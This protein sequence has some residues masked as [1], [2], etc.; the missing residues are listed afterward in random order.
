MPKI[1]G[2]DT[3][4]Q[5][6]VAT[7]DFEG[8]LQN[9]EDLPL[10]KKEERK[11]MVINKRTEQWQSFNLVNPVYICDYIKE[12]NPEYVFVEGVTGSEGKNAK[13]TL[14]TQGYNYNAIFAGLMMADFDF[15]NLTVI[16][17]NIWKKALGV[18]GKKNGNEKLKMFEY[19]LKIYPEHKELF[20]GPRGGKL[21]GRTDA[22]GIACF[23][24]KDLYKQ[25]VL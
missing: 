10:I 13:T 22:I 16:H 9:V 23:G 25:G 15:E 3:G 11:R 8:N 1:T 7:I 24:L 19:A 17:S 18:H 21:D 6:A 2:F 4:G 12:N 5:G 20:Y 14:L